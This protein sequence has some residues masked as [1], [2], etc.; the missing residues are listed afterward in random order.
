[1][2][3]KQTFKWLYHNSRSHIPLMVLL[4]VGNS[5]FALCGVLFALACRGVIDSTS[6]GNKSYLFIQ[7]LKLLVVIIIQLILRVFCRYTAAKMQGKLEMTYKT[8]LL[9]VILHKDYSNTMK[10][11]SGD[12]LNRLTS[13]VTV[14]SEG[15]SNILPNFAGLMTKLISS[16]VILFML[17]KMFTLIFI[18]GGLLLFFTTKF[19]RSRLKYFHKNVQEK[20]G[21]LRSFI[22]EVLENIIVVKIFG[23]EK[24][25]ENKT[26]RFG[27]DHYKAKLK[28]NAIGIMANTGFSFVFSMAYL[29][30]L[31]WSSLGMIVKTISFG[32]L[33]A[34]LQLVGQVQ[35]PFANLS[36]MLPMVYNV[37]ASAERMMEIENLPEELEINQNDI[38]VQSV[39]KNMNSIELK[40]LS[41]GYGQKLVINHVD[42]NIKKGDFIVVS[43]LSGIG[44]STLFKLML[45]ILK[46]DDGIIYI[47]LSNGQEL[48]ID[49]H[50]RKLFA[51]VPQGNLL[52][53]G[54]IRDNIAFIKSD[55]T[56]KEIIDAAKISCAFDFIQM[57]PS[58]L[59]TKIGEKGHGLSEGQVQ[60][61]AIA[62]A[63]LSDAPILLLDESTSA[64]DELT[65]EKLLQ[66]LKKMTDKTCV[67]ISHKKA[68]FSI[69]NKEIRFNNQSIAIIERSNSNVY[70]SARK[71]IFNLP[72]IINY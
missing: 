60:R 53:S 50:T 44:K 36:G 29:F 16:L 17:D 47:K 58:G 19:F 61:L 15:I 10:F 70:C 48:S 28:K 13:D 20:D 26:I 57:L 1:M 9:S 37:L 2:K 52:L 54:S 67:I 32:T 69:C 66:N 24:E 65:E 41:F 59:D 12:L 71:K 11:H 34:I 51:Y 55:A 35:T 18:L 43:G 45:G 21:I 40:N 31:V 46:P 38:N 33:T 3:D 42:L 27:T 39:Y 30:A 56:D 4:M 68:A 64:L 7:S 6:T 8:K 25:F 23:A 49:K 63:L 14:V 62:R 5:L 22:Q 72:A